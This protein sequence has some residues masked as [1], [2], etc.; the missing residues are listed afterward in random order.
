[1]GRTT[2][3]K[4]GHGSKL[5]RMGYGSVSSLTGHGQPQRIIVHCRS[6]QR[7]KKAAKILQ[8]NGFE[9]VHNLLGGILAWREAFGAKNVDA[10]LAQD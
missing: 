9:K 5:W 2:G 1:M 6:G 10:K 7:S 8:E 4:H 3:D